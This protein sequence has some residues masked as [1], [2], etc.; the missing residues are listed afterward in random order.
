MVQ[1]ERRA[2]ANIVQFR[3]NGTPASGFAIHMVE[4]SRLA[5]T[6]TASTYRASGPIRASVP[7]R[8]RAGK[9]IPERT[10]RL[11]K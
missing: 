5:F 3:T 6:Y 2:Y 8:M 10:S 9:S 7:G 11:T 4:E 1:L